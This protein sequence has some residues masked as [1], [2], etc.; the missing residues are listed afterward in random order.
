[1]SIWESIIQGI[2]QGVAEF[3][4][5]SSSG[6]LNIIHGLFG[7]G[8]PLPLSF[9]VLLHLFSLIAVIIIFRKKIGS[10][11]TG[12]LTGIKVKKYN[13]SL[14]MIVLIVVAT[15]PTAIIGFLGKDF[16]EENLSN[17]AIV[18]IVLFFNGILLY[19]SKFFQ[20]KSLKLT[21][22]TAL[23]I[24]IVQ[25]LAITPG[26]SRSGSTISIAILLG[27]HRE[28]AGEFSFLLSIPAILGGMLLSIKDITSINSDLLGIY[29]IGGLFAFVIGYCSLLMLLKLIKKGHF[30]VFAYYC[31]AVSIPSAIYFISR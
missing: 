21:I 27:I 30:Y 22:K 7:E 15:I 17:P 13:D 16:L 6:H 19:S 12:G 31:W 1:M 28:D 3:L 9:N 20:Q 24:G 5:I 8:E 18:S 25:G 4:P 29:L 11:I 26:I 2:V 10:L 23:I 14:Q